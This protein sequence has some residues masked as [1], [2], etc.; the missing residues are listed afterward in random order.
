MEE[1]KKFNQVNYTDAFAEQIRDIHR[2]CQIVLKTEILDGSKIID[3]GGGPGIAAHLIDELGIRATVLNLEPSE[4]ATVIPRLTSVEYIPQNITFKE[5]LSADLPWKAD[6]LLL[7]SSAHEIALSYGK[8]ARENKRLFWDD[9]KCFMHR[10]LKK[11]GRIIISF[12]GY[13]P[14]ATP[15]QALR[16]QEINQL[17]LGHS[18]P[19]DEYFY[20][21]DFA[22]IFPKWPVIVKS[23]PMVLAGQ[24]PD[25]GSI[26]TATVAV[27][28]SPDI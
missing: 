28:L 5:A 9:L 2:L 24:A 14:G 11:N 22:Y 21:A 15:E 3:L 6:R 17:L 13:L 25:E 26:L 8:T 27:F 18:H 12:P 19:Y 23:K 4:N 1:Y 20:M 16:Q 7:M 10:S